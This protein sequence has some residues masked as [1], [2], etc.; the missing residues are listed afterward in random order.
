MNAPSPWSYHQ[1]QNAVAIAMTS[2]TSA[3]R[4][5]SSR[6]C[7]MRL[8]VAA[9]SRGG[10]RL[11]VAATVGPPLGLR[12]R[13]GSDTEARGGGAGPGGGAAPPPPPRL[14]RLGLGR[15]RRLVQAHRVEVDLARHHG[16][17]A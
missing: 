9:A 2:S 14:G 4:L 15:A 11:R 12:P 13:G 16:G 3:I 17:R 6:R 7:A 8:I 10:R 5:R 1:K